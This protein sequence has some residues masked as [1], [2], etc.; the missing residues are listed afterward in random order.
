MSV[1]CCVMVLPGWNTEV[2]I[3]LV[4]PLHLDTSIQLKYL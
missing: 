4:R 1:R 2:T 3:Q